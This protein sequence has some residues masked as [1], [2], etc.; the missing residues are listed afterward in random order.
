MTKLNPKRV[1]L[2]TPLA[3]R[4]I[5]LTNNAEA[6]KAVEPQLHFL[7]LLNEQLVLETPANEPVTGKPA[8][9]VQVNSL[10]R[11]E[12]LL[13]KLFASMAVLHKELKNS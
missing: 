2:A 13:E 6:L 9:L 7:D 1:K 10:I 8:L 3:K 12:L 4:Y 5:A 11:D